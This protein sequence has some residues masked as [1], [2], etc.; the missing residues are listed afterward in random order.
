MTRRVS[1]APKLKACP[2]CGWRAIYRRATAE[3]VDPPNWTAGCEYGCAISVDLPS[4]EKAAEW[5]N[6]RRKPIKMEAAA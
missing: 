1:P 2:F 6:R 5:W 4:K 3:W